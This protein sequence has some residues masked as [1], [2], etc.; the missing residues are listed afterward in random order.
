MDSSGRSDHDADDQGTTTCNPDAA[1]LG[2]LGAAGRWRYSRMRRARL[3]K[4]IEPIRMPVSARGHWSARNLRACFPGKK[5]YPP[6]RTLTK[7]FMSLSRSG[8]SGVGIVNVCAPCR[9][10]MSGSISS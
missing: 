5:K 3:R 1:G 2:Y 4:R 8:P 7:S 10:P 9:L 6:P